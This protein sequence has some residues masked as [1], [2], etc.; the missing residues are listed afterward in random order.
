MAGPPSSQVYQPEDDAIKFWPPAANAHPSGFLNLVLCSLTQ[1]Y[2]IPDPVD[3]SLGDQITSQLLAA[4][5]SPA[6]PTVATLAAVTVQQW[7]SFF[8]Q[9]PS[10][11][12]P[13]TQPAIR[14]R[15]L[16]HSFAMSRRSSRST[17]AAHP[18]PLTIRPMLQPSL[19]APSFHSH[20]PPGS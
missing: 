20:R 17:P 16:L 1:G 19:E 6:S 8:Q 12:P 10:W 14:L 5:T 2:I 4:L 13:F 3:A 18:V 15:G 9:H 7:S 11:L